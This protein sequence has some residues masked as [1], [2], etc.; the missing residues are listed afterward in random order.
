MFQWHDPAPSCLPACL[1]LCSHAAMF[2]C[3]SGSMEAPM[4]LTS[5]MLPSCCDQKACLPHHW[6]VHRLLL[7]AGSALEAPMGLDPCSAVPA[8]GLQE[9]MG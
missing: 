9:G 5:Y 3:Y 2:R 4:A 8:V 7:H 1:L 6:Y